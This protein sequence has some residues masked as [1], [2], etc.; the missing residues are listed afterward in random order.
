M[1]I[2]HP[3]QPSVYLPFSPNHRFAGRIAKLQTLERKLFTEQECQEV[4][5]V[6]LGGIGKTQIALSFVYSVLESHSEFSVYWV[7][8]LNIETLQQAFKEIARVIGIHP[9]SD[10]QEDIK[11]V[12][13]RHLHCSVRSNAPCEIYTLP[14]ADPSRCRCY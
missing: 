8:A 3:V 4:A 5:I 9:E 14:L 1:A 12:V 6:G 11:R 2:D 7:P 10:S 13:Q